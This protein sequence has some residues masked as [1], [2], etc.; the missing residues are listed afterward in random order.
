MSG[1][2]PSGGEEMV[3]FEVFG[4]AAERGAACYVVGTFHVPYGLKVNRNRRGICWRPRDDISIMIR[5][6]G[7]CAEDGIFN[8]EKR[9]RIA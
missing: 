8:R 4:A 6:L 5:R 3:N 7:L 2:S 9:R 1:F